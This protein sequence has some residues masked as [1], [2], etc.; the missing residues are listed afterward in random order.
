[1]NPNAA[2][3]D[4]DYL[5]GGPPAFSARPPLAQRT[6][7]NE[8]ET[9]RAARGG[10]RLRHEPQA[11]PNSPHPAESY[12]APCVPQSRTNPSRSESWRAMRGT[13]SDIDGK[14][15]PSM[16]VNREVL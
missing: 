14:L 4:L 11:V 15:D 13:A 1:M 8:P 2:A 5:P 16:V 6:Q 9:S 10:A 3:T 7:P 12:A